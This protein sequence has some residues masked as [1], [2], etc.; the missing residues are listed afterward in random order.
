MITVITRQR[1]SSWVRSLTDYERKWCLWLNIAGRVDGVRRFFAFISWLGNGKFWYV[2]MPMLI[3]IYGQEAI[4]PVLH[5]GITALVGIAVYLFL[6]NRL[7]RERPFASM[8]SISK[9]APPIDQYSFPS[10]HMLHA[11]SFSMITLSYYPIL[12]WWLV[13]FTA[14]IALS[15]VILGLHYPTDVLAGAALGAGLASVSFYLV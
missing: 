6:K 14:L 1:L 11:V 9:G 8:Q 2:M 5:M 4:K 3:A 13:P 10:G 15:R 7:V 12:F